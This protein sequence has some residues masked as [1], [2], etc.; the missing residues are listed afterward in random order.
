MPML[1]MHIIRRLTTFQISVLIQEQHLESLISDFKSWKELICTLGLDVLL[2]LNG[3][4][5]CWTIWLR[6]WDLFSIHP[7][8]WHR[9]FQSKQCNHLPLQWPCKMSL[10]FPIKIQSKSRIKDLLYGNQEFSTQKN[11]LIHIHLKTVDGH[12]KF[13]C[14]L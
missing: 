3:E 8:N 6:L 12:C 1:I 7:C 14:F 4:E 13:Y 11:F 10:H 9:L 2:Y 5:T